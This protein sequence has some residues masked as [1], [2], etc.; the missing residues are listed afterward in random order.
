MEI[1]V[2]T[3][4]SHIVGSLSFIFCNFLYVIYKINKNKI[5]KESRKIYFFL[6][7]LLTLEADAPLASSAVLGVRVDNLAAISA[8]IVLL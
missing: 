1:W 8:K 7:F 2:Y 5:Y 4:G 3:Y 6:R